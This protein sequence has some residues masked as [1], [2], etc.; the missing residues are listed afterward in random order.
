MYI[1]TFNFKTWRINVSWRLTHFQFLELTWFYCSVN[2]ME[3]YRLLVCHYNVHWK[4]VLHTLKSFSRFLIFIPFHL[5]I[6]LSI[7]ST[8]PSTFT[9]VRW[10]SLKICCHRTTAGT[11]ISCALHFASFG[12]CGNHFRLMGLLR[13]CD[14]I[15]TNFFIIKPTRCTSFSNLLWHETLHVLGSSS[16]H[17]KEFIYCTL[18]TGVCHTGL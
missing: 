17:H 11:N 18:G 1:T 16:A 3:Y 4:F 8:F 7:L 14:S 9:T 15:V 12:F 5:S 2:V 13:S 10:M 6:L